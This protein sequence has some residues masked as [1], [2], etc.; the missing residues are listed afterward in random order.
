[1]KRFITCLLVVIMLVVSM[2]IPAFAA[3][4]G[5]EVA[6]V[7]SVSG[8]PG[9]GNCQVALNYNKD[10]L[11]YVRAEAC[12]VSAGTMVAGSANSVGIISF[13]NISGN[14]EF[15][16]VVFKVAD[17][18]PAGTYPVTGNVTKCMDADGKTPVTLNVTGGS[19]TVEIPPCAVHTYG[20]LTGTEPTC[21]EDGVKTQTCSE[22]GHV[23]T[24]TTPATGHTYGDWEKVDDTNHKKTCACGD[25]VTAAHTWNA[26]E[27]TKP[28]SCVDGE[29]TFTCTG[30][31]ATKVEP[32]KGTGVHTTNTWTDAGDGK[33]H[34]G[35]CSGCGLELTADHKW[36]FGTVT[37]QPSC[38]EAGVKTFKCTFNCGAEKT[39]EIK[40]TGFHVYTDSYVDNKDGKTHTGVCACGTKSTVAQN[41]ILVLKETINPD[42][43]N[44]GKK[45]YECTVCKGIVETVLESTGKHNY[46]TWTTDGDE[47][48]TSTCTGCGVEKKTEKHVW[49]AGK[50]TT[51]P[52]CENKGVKTYTCTAKGC[53]Q[54]KTEEVAAKGHKMQL[55][56]KV[57]A[58]CVAEGVEKYACANG[59]GETE[60]KKLP[61]DENAHKFAYTNNEATDNHTVT[62]ENGCGKVNFQEDHNHNIFGGIVNGKQ[63]KLCVCGDKIEVA[64]GG[65]YADL[66]NVPKTGDITGQIVAFAA[67]GMAALMAVAF[68]FKRKAAK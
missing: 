21:T 58:T 45:V 22:C 7:F 5:Q 12:G 46:E 18:A 23:N 10:V 16:K 28:A 9:F 14:G 36:D 65:N 17:K 15:F 50:I 29:K 19:V 26:G 67:C 31:G 20:A 44:D 59:C 47:T 48:H 1:M 53:G 2:A 52:D 6:V 39:E 42:C 56:E 68:V 30:C 66:D 35:T 32:V 41:H 54:T 62:C 38:N 57:A 37:K 64:L 40:A 43:K 13:A 55:T 51:E 11:T 34:K 61:V 8:N 49:D 27:I 60:E 25:V 24:V 63:E 4:R 33:T 3:E